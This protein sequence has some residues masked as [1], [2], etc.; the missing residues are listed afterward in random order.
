[1]VSLQVH[2]FGGSKRGFQLH[3]RGQALLLSKGSVK[4]LRGITVLKQ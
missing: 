2:V 1:M 3:L 4:P